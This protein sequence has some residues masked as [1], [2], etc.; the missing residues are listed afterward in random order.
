MAAWAKFCGFVLR[1]MGWTTIGGPCPDKKAIILG[2]P[3]TSAMDFVISYL[4]Y[5][6]FNAGKA[7]VMIK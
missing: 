7:R 6:Q 4:F 1:K 2:V 3:H 5:T